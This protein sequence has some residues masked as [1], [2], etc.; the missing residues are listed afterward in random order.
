VNEVVASTSGGASATA[1]TVS[2]ALITFA[3]RSTCITGG[4]SST[5]RRTGSPP[6]W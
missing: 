2:V 6:G 5:D 4:V 1:L 3:T